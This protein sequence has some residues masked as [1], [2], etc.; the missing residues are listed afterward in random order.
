[1]QPL[2]LSYL[3]SDYERDIRLLTKQFESLIETK[4]IG[5]SV[6]NR[7]IHQFSIGK[8]KHRIHISASH[9]AREWMT[10]WLTTQQL[11]YFVRLYSEGA[12]VD[13]QSIREMLDTISLHFLPMVNPDGVIL[14]TEGWKGVGLTYEEYLSMAENQIGDAYWLWKANVR[15]VDLNRQYPMNWGGIRN[16]PA[17]PAAM[18]YKGINH[19]SEPEVWALMKEIMED[20]PLMAIAYHSAGEEIYWY[21]GQ[22]GPTKERD[23]ELALRFGRLTEY[24]L[25]PEDDYFAGGFADWFVESYQRPGFTVEIGREPHPVDLTQ[26]KTIWQRNKYVPLLALQEM[27]GL[28]PYI[29]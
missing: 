11:H 3:Y 24:T 15:G 7:P 9:H 28:I 8:G 13:G 26:S 22:D 29:K 19:S 14:A 27:L 10:S 25:I 12:S 2:F 23:F 18:N 21:H 1:M 17:T 6:Q 16:S 5:Y 4:V 20:P